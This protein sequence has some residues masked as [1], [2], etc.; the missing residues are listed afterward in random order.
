MTIR[1][2]ESGD[3]G[4][5]GEIVREVVREMGAGGNP[6]WNASYPDEARFQRDIDSGALYVAE[7][8]GEIL[9]FAAMD[10]DEPEGY[11]ALPWSA[12]RD[13]VVIHRLAVARQSRSLGV[14]SRLEAFLCDLAREQGVGQI[15]V[16]THSTNAGMQA[17]L[18]RQGYRKVGETEFS[19]RPL[20]FICY[21][22]LL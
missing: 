3:L 2:A 16:D 4:R 11:H 14:A 18:T 1:Q 7:E 10:R 19:G 5:V 12:G 8:N 6:Q 9:G 21:E 17:F 13:S 20:P 22:K 15:K